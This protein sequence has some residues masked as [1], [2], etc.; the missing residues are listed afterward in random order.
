MGRTGDDGETLTSAAVFD[1]AFRWLCQRRKD[2]PADADVWNFRRDW[3]AAS[4]RIRA[5][6]ESGAYRFSPMT[7]VERADGETVHLAG[8]RFPGLL[9]RPVGSVTQRFILGTA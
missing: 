3:P 8:R 4:E 5:E 1:Q 2:Y 9:F 6:I 7:R